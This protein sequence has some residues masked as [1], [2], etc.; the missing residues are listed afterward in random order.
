[1]TLWIDVTDIYHWGLGHLTGIQRASA[2]VLSELMV[3]RSDIQLFAYH[4]SEQVLR[5]VDVC[6]LPPV[7][8]HHI[9]SREGIAASDVESSIV[10]GRP[11]KLRDVLVRARLHWGPR[12]W[13]LKPLVR[14]VRLVFRHQREK[15]GS[16]ETIEAVKGLKRSARHLLSLVWR[17]LTGLE[18]S[19]QSLVLTP[20]Q[21]IKPEET[22]FKKGDVCLALSATWGF[23]RYG[24]VIAANLQASGA[25]CI[26]TLYDLIPTLFP[27]WVLAGQS[28]MITL[29]ARQQIENADVVL[30]ISEF[31]KREISGYIETDRLPERPIEVIHLGDSP[32]LVAATSASPPLPRYVPERK[33]VICVSTLDVRKNH[34]LLYRVWQRLAEELGPDCPQLLFIGTPHLHVSDLLHQIRYDRSVNKVI[35]HLADVS[36][37]E[38]AWYYKNCAFTIYPSIYEGWGL[39][40]SESLSLGR[41]CIAGNRTSLPEAGGDLVDYFDPF[42]FAACYKLVYKAATDPDYVQAYEERIRANYV[43]YRWAQT[44]AHISEIVDRLSEPHQGR[45][46]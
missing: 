10:A 15:W 34:G 44:A 35:V 5:K 25:K 36:D 18:R 32:K 7:V 4:P 11:Q 13:F 2:S 38:L 14:R 31:Q 3:I 28:Q 9:G 16:R 45:V 43:P 27:Q 8:R 21:T 30:T 33:F 22:I 12:L 46:D 17:N 37:E 29:W 1:M 6:S 24:D 42:D 40:I 20:I 41:Y 23:T 39:P 19:A 26:N